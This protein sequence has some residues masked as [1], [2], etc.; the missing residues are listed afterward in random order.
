[1]NKIFLFIFILGIVLIFCFNDKISNHINLIEKFTWAFGY[2][3]KPNRK[4]L[5][6]G[7]WS[8][9]C[10]V[11]DYRHPFLW[12]SCENDH[13]KAMDASID[14]GKCIDNRIRNVNGVLECD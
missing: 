6:P 13:G 2:Y 10:I 1:M 14:A 3:P 4:K 8:R 7:S 12:A 5:P 9:N 11:Q